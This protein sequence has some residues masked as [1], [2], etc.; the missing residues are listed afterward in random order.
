MIVNIDGKDIEGSRVIISNFEGEY[1]PRSYGPI[2]RHVM[3]DNKKDIWYEFEDKK[4]VK[5]IDVPENIKI[6]EFCN[7]KLLGIEFGS[8]QILNKD[9]VDVGYNVDCNNV[10]SDDVDWKEVKCKL[11]PCKREDLKVGDIAFI[12]SLDKINEL[13]KYCVILNEEEFAYIKYKK[14]IRIDNFPWKSW[15]KVVQKEMEE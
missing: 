5:E 3:S 6:M 7:N 8:N 14:E 10:Y 4:N 2:F 11:V 13:A 12:H 9:S 1:S 15:W